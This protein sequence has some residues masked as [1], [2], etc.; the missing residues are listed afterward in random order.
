MGNRNAERIRNVT[1]HS[2]KVSPPHKTSQHRMELGYFH[3]QRGTK[4][5]S[6][7]V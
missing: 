3:P 5:H 4:P 7:T 1:E 6:F 2:G